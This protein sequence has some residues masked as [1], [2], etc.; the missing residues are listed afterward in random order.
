MKHKILV[1]GT[2]HMA[3]AD[4]FHG[5]KRDGIFSEQTQH[6]I[7]QLRSR[8]AAFHP[9]KIA[10]EW[11]KSA[12]PSLD[13]TYGAYL[14]GRFD[15]TENEIFQIAFP[16]AKELGQQRLYAVDWMERGV[17]IRGYGDIYEYTEQNQPALFT[18]LQQWEMT[19]EGGGILDT[20]RK[21]NGPEAE[22]ATKAYYVITPGSAWKMTTTALAGSC[23]GISGT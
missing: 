3:G 11:E 4:D 16:L 21:L 18:Q 17:G 1:L 8:L 15:L 2:F 22:A 7:V 13:R 9:T 5:E 12:Q 20:L 19:T 10:V 23:G 14:N 6:E